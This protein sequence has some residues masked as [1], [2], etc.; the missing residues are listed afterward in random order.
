MGRSCKDLDCVIEIFGHCRGEYCYP[1][2]QGL[3]ERAQREARRLGHSLSPFE[4]VRN[5]AVWRAECERCG[6]EAAITLSAEAGEP[7][8][9][10]DALGEACS[11]VEDPPA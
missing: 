10:G 6:L 4:K 1:E 3:I 9:Y 5:Y 2:R 8:I 7:E 11:S